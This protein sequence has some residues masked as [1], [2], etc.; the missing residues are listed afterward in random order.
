MPCNNRPDS[1]LR[2]DNYESHNDEKRWG[3]AVLGRISVRINPIAVVTLGCLVWAFASCW[4][5]IGSFQVT[6]V[7]A[8]ALLVSPV[9]LLLWAHL[10]IA[11]SWGQD[12]WLAVCA[13]LLSYLSF[14]ASFLMGWF[15]PGWVGIAVFTAILYAVAAICVAPLLLLRKRKDLS[16][17]REEPSP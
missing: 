17:A 7:V 8:I 5:L 2:P 15:K 16:I 14:F 6:H 1:L 13:I 10:R 11:R 12:A 3:A 9:A 4:R